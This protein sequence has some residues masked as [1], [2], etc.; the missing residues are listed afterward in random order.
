MT[1]RKKSIQFNIFSKEPYRTI[2]FVLIGAFVFVWLAIRFFG[3]FSDLKTG[4]ATLILALDD[5]GQKRMF[6][7]AVVDKMTILDVLKASSEAGQ[8]SL[9]F[10]IDSEQV[11][12]N[13]FN[14]YLPAEDKKL[15]FYLNGSKTEEEEIHNVMIEPGD[16][17]EVKLE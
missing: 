17:V 4:E 7:G 1:S 5:N 11:K 3:G 8:I 10:S 6:Q 13:K 14:G 2:L 15:V 12:I 16:M 9:E